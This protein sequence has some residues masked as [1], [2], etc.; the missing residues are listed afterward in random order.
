M[1]SRVSNLVLGG[2]G[3]VSK[4]VNGTQNIANPERRRVVRRQ[5]A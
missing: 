3:E 2:A 1:L 5:S 4:F